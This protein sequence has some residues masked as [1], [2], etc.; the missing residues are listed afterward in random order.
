MISIKESLLKI[1]SDNF[2]LEDSLYYD[3]LNLTSFSSYILPRVKQI[4]KKEVTIWSIKMALSRIAQEKQK[5][6]THKK[7]QKDNIFIKKNINLISLINSK[8]SNDLI[9]KI[10]SSNLPWYEN[11][12]WVT[13]W[14]KEID[15]IYSKKIKSQI[16]LLIKQNNVNTKL[17]LNN[18]WAIWIHLDKELLNTVWIIYD[19]TKKLTFFNVNIVTM[20]S[21]YTEISFIVNE[22]DLKKAFD[23]MII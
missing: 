20:L 1:I 14:I 8:K 16:D 5:T 23:L 9:Y 11:Y 10:Y 2:F 19:L 21:T 6:I 4:T 3:Y 15:I 12:F 17:E 7:I 13:R 22:K 18:L